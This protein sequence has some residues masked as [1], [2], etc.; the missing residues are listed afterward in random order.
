MEKI[1]EKLQKI[2]PILNER[3]RRIVFAAEAEQLGRGG[4]SQIQDI[5]WNYRVNISFI[6]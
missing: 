1:L 3:Q 2:A 6:Q 5:K 4:K